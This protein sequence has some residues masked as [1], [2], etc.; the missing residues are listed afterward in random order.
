MVFRILVDVDRLLWI[1]VLRAHKV[2]RL[3]S[4]DGDQREPHVGEVVPDLLEQA[5]LGV[6]GIPG[7]IDH[8][9]RDV[10]SLLGRGIHIYLYM[11]MRVCRIDHEISLCGQKCYT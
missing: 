4:S 1:D 9:L 7:K 8:V 10:A 6:A 5:A 3:V 2:A 11:C